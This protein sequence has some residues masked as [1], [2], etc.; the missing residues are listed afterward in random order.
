MITTALSSQFKGIRVVGDGFEVEAVGRGGSRTKFWVGGAKLFGKAVRG[1]EAQSYPNESGGECAHHPA[2]KPVGGD[3]QAPH[4]SF[5]RGYGE[6][7][8][9]GLFLE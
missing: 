2:E 7:R 8:R 9:E 6:V 5:A 1:V 4:S 3:L